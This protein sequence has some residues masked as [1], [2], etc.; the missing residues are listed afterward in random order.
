MSWMFIT[1]FVKL[2]GH[3]IR[4]PADLLLLPVSILFGYLHGLIKLYAM[5]SLNVVCSYSMEL[6]ILARFDLAL[7]SPSKKHVIPYPA[8]DD[9]VYLLIL[10]PCLPFCMTA[11]C[12]NLADGPCRPPGVAAMEQTRMMHIA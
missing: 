10:F 8:R 7:L 3:Y 6:F 1:K 2:L 4:Y 12:D 11:S 9:Q 5:L